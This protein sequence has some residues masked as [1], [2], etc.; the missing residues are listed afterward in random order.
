LE[1]QELADKERKKAAAFAALGQYTPLKHAIVKKDIFYVT[2]DEKVETFGYATA[3]EILGFPA[4]KS[5]EELV[6]ILTSEKKKIW[7]SKK[8]DGNYLISRWD[9]HMTEGEAEN[10]ITILP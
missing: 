8:E 5:K 6:L 7:V 2:G 1:K 3:R 4:F 9:H 10:Y